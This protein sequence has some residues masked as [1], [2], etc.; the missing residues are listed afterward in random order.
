MCQN[1]HIEYTTIYVCTPLQFIIA[2]LINNI[3]LKYILIDEHAYIY[4]Y[5][6]TYTHI[7]IYMQ[8][9]TYICI[10][11]YIYIYIY[12]IYICKQFI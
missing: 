6:H 5:K 3:H 2:I 9:H 10:Y 11:I 8:I 1:S 4:M 7:Y 12:I